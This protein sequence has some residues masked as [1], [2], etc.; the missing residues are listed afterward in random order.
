LDGLCAQIDHHR[1]GTYQARS[2]T[3]TQ[4]EEFGRANRWNVVRH[5][6]DRNFPK[7]RAQTRD[8]EIT[9]V[10]PSGHTLARA[11]GKEKGRLDGTALED[12]SRIKSGMTKGGNSR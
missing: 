4:N 7:I 6:N 10:N 11:S 1:F 3:M 2:A 12:G 8:G 9:I 5:A